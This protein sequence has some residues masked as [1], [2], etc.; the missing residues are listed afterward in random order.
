MRAPKFEEIPDSFYKYRPLGQHAHQLD[1]LRSTILDDQFYWA[2]PSQFNDPF[3]CA[4]VYAMPEGKA[5]KQ[6]IHRLIKEHEPG[7]T[8]GERRHRRR[9]M[10]ESGGPRD[11]SEMQEAMKNALEESPVYSLAQSPTDILMWSHYGNAHQGVCLQFDGKALV[12]EFVTVYPVTYSSDRPVIQVGFEDRLDQLEKLL[13]TKSDVWTYEQ[14][15]RFV[16]WR[17]R[18][19]G[20]RRFRP[21]ALTGII[22]GPRIAAEH[23]TKIEGWVSSR[24]LPLALYRAECDGEHFGVNL[25]P[26]DRSGKLPTA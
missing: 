21:D 10:L 1:W 17:S 16:E 12:R 8:R 5:F 9:K 15:W 11:R 18:N 2:A 13:L 22:F 20:L 3:D 19:I 6:L 4:P 7:A 23:R 26:I 24:R 25:I 14:E